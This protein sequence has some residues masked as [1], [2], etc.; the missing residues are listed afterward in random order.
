[1]HNKRNIKMA[2]CADTHI[3]ILTTNYTKQAHFEWRLHVFVDATR[4]SAL[5]KYLPN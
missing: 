2:Q 5:F 3:S 4:L 1:M